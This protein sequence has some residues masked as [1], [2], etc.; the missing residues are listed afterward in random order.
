MADE[1]KSEKSGQPG[2]KDWKIP[3]PS[4]PG[5]GEPAEKVTAERA[6]ANA[7]VQ[8]ERGEELEY[9]RSPMLGVLIAVLFGGVLLLGAGVGYYFYTQHQAAGSDPFAV[10][11]TRWIIG[12]NAE[13]RFTG[14]WGK[15]RGMDSTKF[16]E[17]AL[18]LWTL[19]EAY[20]NKPYDKKF[21]NIEDQKTTLFKDFVKDDLMGLEIPFKDFFSGEKSE[22]TDRYQ[23]QLSNSAGH[24]GDG[25]YRILR[26]LMS[27]KLP[28]ELAE[29]RLAGVLQQ[30]NL[31]GEKARVRALF[32]V[33]HAETSS[34][35]QQVRPMD[36]PA[37]AKRFNAINRFVL[38]TK[39]DVILSADLMGLALVTEDGTAIETLMKGYP[40]AVQ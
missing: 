27:F 12:S 30:K 3:D 11:A 26:S 16:G 5:R 9:S 17:Y 18:K 36:L 39:A 25:G 40:G 33:Y 10:P 21:E 37:G 2:P 19:Q 15:A 34:D 1:T 4:M 7:E 8:V 20:L 14:E 35:V 29:Q 32:S 31:A 24:T 28:M 6:G 23:L 22:N 38:L 13:K